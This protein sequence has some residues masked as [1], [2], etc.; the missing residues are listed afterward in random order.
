M[1]PGAVSGD[2]SP[3]APWGSITE[4]LTKAPPPLSSDCRLLTLHVLSGTYRENV[5]LNSTRGLQLIGG[6]PQPSIEGTIENNMSA[7]LFIRNLAVRNA[8]RYGLYQSGGELYVSDSLFSSTR[9]IMGEASSGVGAFVEGGAYVELK[10]VSFNSNGG[11]GFVA[12]G[13]GTRV[14]AAVVSATGNRAHIDAKKAYAD[15]RGGF[16][17]AIEARDGAYLSGDFL[18]VEKNEAVGIAITGGSKAYLVNSKITGT[19]STDFGHGPIGVNAIA[20]NRSDVELQKFFIADAEIGVYVNHGFLTALDGELA[21]HAFG[22][23]FSGLEGQEE[24]EEF[25]PAYCIGKDV[26]FTDNGQKAYFM[27]LFPIP[28]GGA[29]TPPASYCHRVGPL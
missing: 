28:R 10:S 21:R 27:D 5:T 8:S 17:A 2:G 12:K 22:L 24:T 19:I 7:R 9:R 4:A 25:N 11:Q 13:A 18:A 6:L 23:V 14:K 16:V 26:L 20:S 1:S 15:T 29:P 3:A